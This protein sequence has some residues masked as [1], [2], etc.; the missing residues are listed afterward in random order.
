LRKSHTELEAR[1][2]TQAEELAHGREQLQSATAEC[3]RLA[4]DATVLVR[5]KHELLEREQLEDTLRRTHTELEGR[6]GHQTAELNR[7]QAL[8]EKEIADRAKLKR[9]RL[10]SPGSCI[11][12]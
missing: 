7:V 11:A 2:Q 12:N 10:N 8:L 6:F 4:N 1:L 3:Q 5:A 9:E